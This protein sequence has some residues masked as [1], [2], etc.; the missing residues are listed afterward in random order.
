MII[1]IDFEGETPIYV[2]LK[3]Q[4]ILGIA[5]GELS[6]GES[7]PSVRQMAEDIGI[8]MHT[9][10]KTY[11]ELKVEGFISIDRRKGAVVNNTN[12]LLTDEYHENLKEELDFIIGEAYCRGITE[13]EF[14]RLSR[15]AFKQYSNR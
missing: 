2:Q 7:L 12:G 13:D 15:V 10:N 5:K 6:Q 11:N 3:R 8:N 9:V 1:K 14:I 4:I